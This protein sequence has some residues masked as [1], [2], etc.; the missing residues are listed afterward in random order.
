MAEEPHFTQVVTLLLWKEEEGGVGGLGGVLVMFLCFLNFC[1]AVELF[2]LFIY[3]SV[4]LSPTKST[5]KSTQTIFSRSV[6]TQL[7][8]HKTQNVNFPGNCVSNTNWINTFSFLISQQWQSW[9]SSNQN[10]WK[11]VQAV[12]T[13]KSL[14]VKQTKKSFDN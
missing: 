12:K 10:I 2:N 9:S 14:K 7:P 13:G 3:F 11:H 8:V 1:I 6:K 4:W 5:N